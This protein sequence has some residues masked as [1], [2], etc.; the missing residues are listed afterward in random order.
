MKIFINYLNL[1]KKFINM[2]LICDHENNVVAYLFNQ[3]II[4]V[5]NDKLMGII[6]GHCVY[7]MQAK[8]IGTYFK[9]KIIDTKGET[10]GSLKTVSTPNKFLFNKEHFIAEGWAMIRKIKEHF[11]PFVEEKLVWSE[12]NFIDVLLM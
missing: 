1:V 2:T 10:I 12:N 6:L 9:E 4:S 8:I 11:C 5:T 3:L 7:G